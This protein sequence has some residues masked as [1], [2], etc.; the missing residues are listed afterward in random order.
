MHDDDGDG[1]SDTEEAG[2]NPI[3]GGDRDPL[4]TWDFVDVPSPAGPATG[5]DGKPILTA[6]SV[7]NKAVTLHDVGAVLSYVGRTLASPEYN[8]DNNS[9]GIADG[10]QLD[11]TPSTIPGEFWHAGPPN[12]AISLQDVAV[13]L[14]SVGHNCAPLP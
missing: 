10:I 12:D 9:D 11:R 2:T 3:Q 5:G 14:S 1:C 6:S 4:S 7:R 13:I 8:A